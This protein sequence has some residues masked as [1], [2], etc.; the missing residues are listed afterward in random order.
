MSQDYGVILT[1][2]NFWMNTQTI[3]EEKLTAEQI[4]AGEKHEPKKII[5][6]LLDIIIEELPNYLN[7]DNLVK[8]LSIAEASLSEK[9][10]L[11]YFIDENLQK[12]VEKRGWG[13]RL[14]QTN[15][16]YLSVINT[17]IAG[18]KSDKRIKETI[19]H[20][21]E[22]MPNGSII[23]TV[24]IVRTHTGIKREPF[25]GVRNVNW[26]RIYVPA[27]SQLLEA[28][29]FRQPDPIYFEEADVSWQPD[30]LIYRTE[31]M[32]K[33]HEASGTKIYEE[34]GKTVFANW[35]MVDPGKS[36]TIYLK[37]KLPFILKDLEEDNSFLAKVK[38]L[39][40]P[41]Q[42]NLFPYTLFFQKQAGA[43][44]SEI[45]SNLKLSDNFRI[46]WKYPKILSTIPEGWQI[47]D[48]LNIDKYWAVLLEKQD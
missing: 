43:M 15:W 12:E 38:N 7:K 40:N 47:S 42:K 18:G 48:E 30:P 19:N 44:P 5:G 20:K 23:N 29:G 39:L 3:T 22:I 1:A 35:T 31:T 11:F 25:S 2:E 45:N 33:V 9:H 4:Q 10:I 36:I 21:S 16:D 14:K 28:Q 32:A 27:G 37:Y 34:E 26:M 46:V 8:L 17:N 13:G 6:D 41:T 24:K